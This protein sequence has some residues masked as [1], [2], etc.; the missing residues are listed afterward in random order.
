M[1]WAF[2]RYIST[3]RLITFLQLENVASRGGVGTISVSLSKDG[4]T[5]ASV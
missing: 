1:G 5:F 2:F 4:L 3:S